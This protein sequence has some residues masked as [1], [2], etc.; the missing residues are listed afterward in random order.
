MGS[1]F[2]AWNFANPYLMYTRRC[3]L[4]PRCLCRS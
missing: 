4:T 3:W 2:D 1:R